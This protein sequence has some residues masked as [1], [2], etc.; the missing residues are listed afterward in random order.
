[1]GK[2]T[3]NT[4]ICSYFKWSMLCLKNNTH[5]TNTHTKNSPISL[6]LDAKGLLHWVTNL[7]ASSR[8]SIILLSKARS[9]AS[10]KAATKIVVNPN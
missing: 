9:G 10:G 7:Y 5:I 3:E 6:A 2:M 1:M 8:I 4:L